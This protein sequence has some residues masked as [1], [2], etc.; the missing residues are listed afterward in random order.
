MAKPK[1]GA[2]HQ[3]ERLRWKPTVDAGEA[4]CA[5]PICLMT[6]RWIPPGTAWALGHD[7]TGTRWIGPVHKRCNDSDGATR[8]NK[9][10]RHQQQRPPSPRRAGN[11]WL[12]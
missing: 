4:F 2:A 8:G 11:R 1:Y 9:M 5:Q 7:D 10:R 6:N 3:R 12:L